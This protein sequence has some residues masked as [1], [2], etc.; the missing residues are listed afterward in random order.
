MSG[1][2]TCTKEHVDKGMEYVNGG[3]EE[4]GE[5]APTSQGLALCMDVARA[6]VALT[7]NATKISLDL[8]SSG[9]QAGSYYCYLTIYDAVNTDGIAWDRLILRVNKWPAEA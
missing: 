5:S 1:K 8:G 7:D 9:I 4:K 2:S 6:Y 3:Y